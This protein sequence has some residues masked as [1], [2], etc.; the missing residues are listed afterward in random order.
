VFL[1]QPTLPP[2]LTV[3]PPGRD[4]QLPT[5]SLR[6]RQESLERLN[7]IMWPLDDRA[8]ADI[9]AD[10]LRWAGARDDARAT[11]RV[12]TDAEL[13]ILADRPGHSIGAHTVHHLALTHQPADTRLREVLDN[14]TALESAIRRPIALFAYPYGEVDADLAAVVSRAGFRAAVTV[15]NGLVSAGTNRLMFPRFEITTSDRGEAFGRRL[16]ELFERADT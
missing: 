7:E 14:K 9:V 10:V 2:V 1:T 13:R 12:L 6:E 11:H 8:R 5:A 4:C 3:R 16:T 15:E